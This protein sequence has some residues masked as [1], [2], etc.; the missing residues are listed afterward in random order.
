LKTGEQ[1]MHDLIIVGGGPAGLSAALAVKRYQLDC[2]ILERGVIGETVYHFPIARPLFSTS[3]EVE[4]EAGALPQ[5]RKPT[6]EEV[7][8]HYTHLVIREQLNV[9][10]GEAVE[11]ITR[12]GE[13]FVVRTPAN[14]YR[15]RAV[16]VATGGFGR[17]RKLN[18]AG[19]CPERVSYQFSEAHPFAMKRVLVVGGGNSAAEAALFLLDAGAQVSLAIRRRALDAPSSMNAAKIKPWVREPLKRAQA[20]GQLDILTSSEVVEILPDSVLLQVINDETPGLVTVPCEHIF[21]L[22]GAD[23]DVR[24]LEEAGAEIA[25]DGRPIYSDEFE[26]TVAGLFVAGHLTRELHMKKAIEVG[27]GVVKY[28]TEHLLE[29]VAV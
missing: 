7:L 5:D 17:Q 11:A 14:V 26:T 29:P 2:L 20:E 22:I 25:A 23:P 12:V 24:L 10:T 15:S 4:L 28:I 1:N 8:A 9:R 3:N 27:A 6:R 18:V 16:L 19:E 13:G 21:A